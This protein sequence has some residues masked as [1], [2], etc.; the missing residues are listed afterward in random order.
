M[1]NRS[2]FIGD[3]LDFLFPNPVCELNYSNDYELL[4]SIMLSAQSTDKRVNLV[5]AVLFSKY[6]SLDSL[7]NA[8]LS[9]L[10]LIIRSVGSFRKKAFYIKEISRIIIDQYGGVV[11][12]EFDKL[13]ILPGIGRKTI[14]VFLS[15]YYGLPAIAVDTH[16]DR[17][18]KRLGIA[19]YDDN[20]LVIEKKLMKF[21]KKEDWARRHL[22]MVLFGRYYCKSLNPDCSNCNFF[23]MCKK[24]KHR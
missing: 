7:K 5:T 21:F 24:N 13:I 6:T 19:C 16:V 18:S 22:Q 4:I 8:D 2:K 1:M 17:V 14:N 15:E 9:D 10:E 11:P 23:N 12:K 3:Y 20:V